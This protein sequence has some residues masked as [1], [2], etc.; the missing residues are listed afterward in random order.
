M[1]SW[2]SCAIRYV[3]SRLTQRILLVSLR[4]GCR[5]YPKYWDKHAWANRIDK[6]KQLQ[7]GMIWVS[8][9]CHKFSRF[10]D[11]LTSGKWNWG[12][13]LYKYGKM[14]RCPNDLGIYGNVKC[15]VKHQRLKHIRWLETWLIW[16]RFFFVHMKFFRWIK[17]QIFRTFF[18]IFSYFIWQWMVKCTH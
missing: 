14:L 15:T 17:K 8:T 1:F 10:L 12:K 16:T 6:D 18:G 7:N 2:Y 4:Y 9:I 11:T 3:P 5:I 13:F